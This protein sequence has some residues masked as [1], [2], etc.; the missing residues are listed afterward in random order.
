[1]TEADTIAGFYAARVAGQIYHR[2]AMRF[3]I[4]AGLSQPSSS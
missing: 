3:E 4:F 1:M 2:K